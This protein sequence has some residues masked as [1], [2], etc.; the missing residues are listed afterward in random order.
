MFRLVAAFHCI[1]IQACSAPTSSTSY[2]GHVKSLLQ[3]Q[4]STTTKEL[5]EGPPRGLTFYSDALLYDNQT[6]RTSKLKFYLSLQL[7]LN[8]HL[9]DQGKGPPL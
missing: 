1:K 4:K 6:L 7:L 3:A 2:H 9:L 8:H 5:E